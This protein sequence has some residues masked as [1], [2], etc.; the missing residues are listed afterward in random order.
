MQHE[1][2]WRITCAGRRP[3]RRG[4]PGKGGRTRLRGTQ[5]LSPPSLSGSGRRARARPGRP[6]RRGERCVPARVGVQACESWRAPQGP[7]L[8]LAPD[9]QPCAELGRPVPSAAGPG[10]LQGG[11]K[12]GS[13]RKV[14]SVG[15]PCGSVVMPVGFIQKAQRGEWSPSRK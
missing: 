7:R 2:V 14:T 9:L 3:Q 6:R 1:T 4:E 11:G 5:S 13:H 12:V 10:P 8:L 15:P